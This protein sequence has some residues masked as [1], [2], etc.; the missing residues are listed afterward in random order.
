MEV[1]SKESSVFQNKIISGILGLDSILG[2][3]IPEKSFVVLVGGTGT[4]KSIFAQQFLW[5][6]LKS[7][8]G[9]VYVS[10]DESPAQ[11]RKDMEAFGW[12][13]SEFEEKKKFAVVDA[14]TSAIGKVR[15]KEKYAVQDISD[16]NEFL[17]VLASAVRDVGGKRVVIDSI[18]PIYLN[19]KVASPRNITLH[20]KR[21]VQGLGATTFAIAH[22]GAGDKVGWGQ[23]IEHLA[24][25]IIRLDLEEV[26]GE[27]VRS[28]LVLKFRGT[29]HSLKRH[30]F[31]ITNSGIVV[32][33]EK[34]LSLK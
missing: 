23:E 22:I 9:A 29:N 13:V 7:G 8:E 25:G 2:G 1:T 34:I 5:E 14:F 32:Y 11:L 24:D 28:I 20:I 16:L 15:E 6:G 17:D 31:E 3:G 21:L 33:P 12:K 30:P 18:N 4:G 10:L 26:K 27:L 19:S